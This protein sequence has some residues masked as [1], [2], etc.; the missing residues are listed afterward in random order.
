VI[1]QIASAAYYCINAVAILAFCYSTYLAVENIGTSG[2]QTM[3]FYWFGVA[4]AA[5]L[6]GKAVHYLA[7]K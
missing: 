6:L 7:G 1:A 4:V 2:M 3:P 5:W